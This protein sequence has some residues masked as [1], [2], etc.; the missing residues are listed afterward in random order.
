MIRSIGDWQ[1]YLLEIVSPL[2][3]DVPETTTLEYQ[4]VEAEIAAVNRPE[5]QV[6]PRSYGI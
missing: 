1:T 5:G 6:Y 3:N 2:L 4:V